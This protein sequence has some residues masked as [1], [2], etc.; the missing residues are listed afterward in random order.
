MEKSLVL[1]D[2]LCKKYICSFL[3]VPQLL[4]CKTR[5]KKSHSLLALLWM[6]YCAGRF[7]THWFLLWCN[8]V[9]VQG[10]SCQSHNP[11][12]FGVGSEKQSMEQGDLIQ[13]S[14]STSSC[15]SCTNSATVF[16]GLSGLQ[17]FF[18]LHWASAAEER[19]RAIPVVFLYAHFYMSAYTSTLLQ[20][21][22]STLVEGVSIFA[23]QAEKKNENFCLLSAKQTHLSSTGNFLKLWGFEE[24]GLEEEV[25][26]FKNAVFENDTFKNEKWQ[27]FVWKLSE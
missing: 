8:W 24:E 2:S 23:D 25:F 1:K 22:S 16:G 7:A 12:G 26:Y 4:C 27:C 17:P 21:Y 13:P 3:S 20:Q 15:F 18:F 10:H 9:I 5:V 19:A 14:P 6:S 11:C